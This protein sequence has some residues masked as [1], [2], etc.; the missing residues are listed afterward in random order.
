MQ[1]RFLLLPW[2]SVL[3]RPAREGGGVYRF[4]PARSLPCPVRA[5]GTI[6]GR[7][8]ETAMRQI[9]KLSRSRATEEREGIADRR[10]FLSSALVATA[11]TAA[12]RAQTIPGGSTAPRSYGPLAD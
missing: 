2:Q 4:D 12:A 10:R 9:Q 6:S 7:T 1:V 8:R 11:W 5:M 3:S